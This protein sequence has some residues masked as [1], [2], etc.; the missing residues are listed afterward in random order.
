M[1]RK[2]KMYIR[3]NGIW[4]ALV[5]SIMLGV[6][7]IKNMFDRSNYYTDMEEFVKVYKSKYVHKHRKMAVLMIF[8]Q[9]LSLFRRYDSDGNK[10]AVKENIDMQKVEQPWIKL[11]TDE[12]NVGFLLAGGIGD[13]VIVANYIYKFREKYGYDRIRIDV[14]AHNSFLGAQ[15][16][17]QP[18]NVIDNLYP[19][20]GNERTFCDYDLFV[21]ITRY[22]NI[23][24]RR[25]NR[26]AELKPELLDYV[27][28]CEKFRAENDRFFSKAGITDGQ[29][30]MLEILKGR[31]RI[32]QPDIYGMLGITE[33]F[34]FPLEIYEN[35]TTYLQKLGLLDRPFITLNRGVDTRYSGNSTKLWPL[36]YYNI[37]IRKIKAKYPD[38]VLVQLGAS[39]ERCPDMDGVDMNLVGRTSLEEVKVLLKHSL[40]HIDGEGGMVHL[41]HALRGGASVV[42]FGPTS[43]DFYGYSENV[44]MV[45][46]GCFSW[47][48]WTVHNWQ[49]KCV[50][51]KEKAPCMCSIL[52]E[53]VY[54]KVIELLEER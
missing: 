43:A 16:V 27:F 28:M 7:Y 29:S 33:Q 45:G 18:G 9:M 31:K 22:P 2:L 26:L 48:E 5:H 10:V 47:C 14:F 49:D 13:F 39:R 24:R 19:E 32:Q 30:A 17:F 35:E 54:G 15:S 34:E 3:E 6:S 52:P 11:R 12:V 51:N 20:E 42:M 40:L 1:L 37:L 23:K 4:K 25:L 41:R 50:R 44:N 8:W 46:N 38:L 53:V 21:Q 36:P